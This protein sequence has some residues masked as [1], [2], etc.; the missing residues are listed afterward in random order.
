M[1]PCYLSSAATFL[2]LWETLHLN[3][4]EVPTS[5][6]NKGLVD[7]PFGSATRVEEGSKIFA[8]RSLNFD[9]T[10]Q[11]RRDHRH[12]ILAGPPCRHRSLKTQ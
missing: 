3:E 12:N 7:L 5:Q 6:R 10:Y 11:L 1:L 9:M 4:R 8:A 2:M